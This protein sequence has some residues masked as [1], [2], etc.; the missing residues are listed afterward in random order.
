MRVAVSAS[1]VEEAPAALAH[2]PEPVV[3][4]A[5]GVPAPE[6]AYRWLS[7]GQTGGGCVE[8]VGATG[9][10]YTLTGADA[11]RTVSGWLRGV[12]V[13][14]VTYGSPRLPQVPNQLADIHA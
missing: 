7:C 4:P 10:A 5:S 13:V 3:E 11:G 6:L 12:P 9:A 14:P 2:P 8:I 1:S